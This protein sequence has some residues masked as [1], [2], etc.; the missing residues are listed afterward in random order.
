MQQCWI[1]TPLE[2]TKTKSDLN[3]EWYLVLMEHEESVWPIPSFVRSP[4]TDFG[5]WSGL[6][7]FL[8]AWQH[9][10]TCAYLGRTFHM[11]RWYYWNISNHMIYG[12]SLN[13]KFE[14]FYKLQNLQ[15]LQLHKPITWHE[16]SLLHVRMLTCSKVL[17]YNYYASTVPWSQSTS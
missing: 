12:S 8:K 7:V 1:P 10:V 15:N 2:P 14:I 3:H 4:N 16:W 6:V 17:H 9:Q 5:V 13:L 11:E